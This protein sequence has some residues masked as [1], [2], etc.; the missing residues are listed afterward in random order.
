[1]PFGVVL[2]A[3]IVLSR[4]YKILAGAVFALSASC[5]LTYLVDPTAWA[6]YARMMGSAGLET[7]YIPCLIVA[8]RLHFFPHAMSIQYIPSLL[9]TIWAL[10][11]YWTRRSQWKW[12]ESGDLLVLVSLLAAP[13][14]WV[15][16]GSLAIPGLLRGAYATRSRLLLILLAFASV[17]TEVELVMGVKVTSALYLWTVPGWFVWCLMAQ[18]TR[19]KEP[20]LQPQ[21]QTV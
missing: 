3:W 7:E 5:A 16:D 9:G 12:E 2:L 14:S 19:H 1:V 20:A 15:Y 21:E 17:T 13:Y 11:Y 18:A 8:F 6:D 4:S 10:G